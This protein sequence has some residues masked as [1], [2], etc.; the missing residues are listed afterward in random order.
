MAEPPRI[1]LRSIRATALH[2]GYV[3]S[4]PSPLLIVIMHLD[5]LPHAIEAVGI[6]AGERVDGGTV[7]GFQ[8]EKTADGRFAV[9]RDQGSGRHHTDAM[10]AGLVEMDAVGAVVFRAGRERFRPVDCV[11]DEMHGVSF[12][13]ESV[14]SAGP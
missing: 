10:V 8:N 5:P 4:V 7:L 13:D 12:C 14:A 6:A 9:A 2:P 11:N 1:S 3:P